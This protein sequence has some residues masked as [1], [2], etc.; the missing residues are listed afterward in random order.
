MPHSA[1]HLSKQYRNDSNIVFSK[2]LF[3]LANFKLIFGTGK[4]YNLNYVKENNQAIF[5]VYNMKS[6]LDPC[7]KLSF[8]CVD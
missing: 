3:F 2:L 1:G 4:E 7:R 8:L 5:L 6:I